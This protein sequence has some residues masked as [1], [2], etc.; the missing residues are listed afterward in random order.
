MI[1]VIGTAVSITSCEP[2]D[3]EEEKEGK[4]AASG[5]SCQVDGETVEFEVTTATYNELTETLN[6]SGTMTTGYPSIS[7][8]I[9]SPTEKD[10]DL[11]VG[12]SGA[13]LTY[14]DEDGTTYQI[15]ANNEDAGGVYVRGLE[16]EDGGTIDGGFNAEVEDEA[17]NKITI[18]S[19]SI[20]MTISYSKK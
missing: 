7:I 5:L 20:D 16:L 18:M 9:M 2:I 19:G 6:I 11:A 17:G 4:I 15:D 3:D 14:M 8:A 12:T 10:Y 13:T 1:L